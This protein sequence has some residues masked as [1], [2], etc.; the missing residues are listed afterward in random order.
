MINDSLYLTTYDFKQAFDS[1]WLQ[2]CLLSL[3]SLDVD[4]YILQLIYEL[5]K[6]AVIQIKTP[7]GLTHPTVANDLVKQGGILGSP[8]CSA[9]TAQYCGVNKGVYIGTAMISSLAFVDDMADISRGCQDAINAHAN[10]ELFA[11]KK[12]LKYS[13]D[14]CKTMIIHKK[15]I[16]EDPELFIEGENV[17]CAHSIKYLGDVFNSKGNNDDLIMDRIKRATS[18]MVSIDGFMREASVGIYTIS[19]YVLVYHAIFLPSVMF[20]S[21]SWTNVRTEDLAKLKMAQQ[22]FLKKVVG[23]NHAANSFLFLELG[24]LPIT[25]ELHIRQLSYLYHIISLDESDPVKQMWRN[26]H[27]ISNHRNWWNGIKEL[28]TRY[29]LKLTEEEIKAMSRETFKN[30]VKTAVKTWHF[31]NLSR[32]TDQKRRPKI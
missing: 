32:N 9:S 6:K 31:K 22:R 13:A 17:E 2:D 19:I 8:M 20:N 21:Q 10:A 24:F 16:D 4:K 25:Y 29:S 11:K 5:N 12:K 14:K 7:Y 1:L 23:E 15:V 30:K 3:R 18:T 27:N 28:M 26:Q